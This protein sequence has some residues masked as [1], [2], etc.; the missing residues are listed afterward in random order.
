MV[1]KI[2]RG[3]KTRDR[4]ILS[5]DRRVPESAPP[6][7][8]SPT[9]QPPVPPE[10]APAVTLLD[11]VNVLLRHRWRLARWMIVIG[12]LSALPTLFQKPTY[13][14]S[15]SFV[16]QG[17][18][19]GRA[20]LAGFAAQLGVQLPVGGGA[21][22]SPQFFADLLH[23]RDV[24]SRVMSDSV[25]DPAG[26]HRV[27]AMSLFALPGSTPEMR[28]DAAI[29]LLSQSLMDVVV[30][31]STGVVTVT[32]TT[33]WP[34]VSRELAEKLLA[35][36][37][38][39][40]QGMRKAQ[41]SEERRFSEERLNASRDSLRIAEDRLAAFT[42][43]NRQ[44]QISSD[45]T[46]ARE[47]L[48]R[49]VNLQQQVFTSLVQSYEDSRLRELR[50]TPVITVIETPVDASSANPRGRVRRFLVGAFVGATL[51]ILV[52]LISHLLH[53]GQERRSPAL[54][55]FGTLIG[56]MR[57]DFTRWLPGRAR[58]DL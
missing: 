9:P 50:D 11:M 34:S 16:L 43:G 23:T 21:G 55:T 10:G 5:P 46:F 48:Q 26:P 38:R 30:S 25:K 51:C 18:D 31:K 4:L 29:R 14:A 15:G 19:Q 37:N 6:L 13:S 36:V 1:V 33:P 8:L 22:Q 45:L 32:V 47:R 35:G 24:L 52:L 44:Y 56:D 3:R 58:H 12:L 20:G 28:R 27:L 2:L 57:G 40:S 7:T 53:S 39:T 54:E 49:D 41:A 17:T 42:R